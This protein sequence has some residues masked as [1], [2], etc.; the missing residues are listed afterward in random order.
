MLLFLLAKKT[1][2]KTTLEIPI[3]RKAYVKARYGLSDVPSYSPWVV[4]GSLERETWLFAC[5]WLFFLH[6]N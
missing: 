4:C 3:I 5:D 1:N 6:V 2:T